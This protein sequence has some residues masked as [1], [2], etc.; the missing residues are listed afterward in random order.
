MLNINKLKW[1]IPFIFINLLMIEN[2]FEI[3]GVSI[4]NNSIKVIC[5]FMIVFFGIISIFLL[6]IRR[7]MKNQSL[8]MLLN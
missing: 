3:Y 1:N 6:F 4:I 8:T 2:L 5:Y 7:E